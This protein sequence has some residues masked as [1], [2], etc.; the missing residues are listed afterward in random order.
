MILDFHEDKEQVSVVKELT[1][2]ET[3]QCEDH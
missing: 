3:G 1:T 2:K